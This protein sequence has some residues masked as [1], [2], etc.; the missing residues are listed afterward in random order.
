MVIYNQ[1]VATYIRVADIRTEKLN[2]TRQK[3]ESVTDAGGNW[4]Q[5]KEVRLGKHVA[6]K[7]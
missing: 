7:L 1:K 3:T 2:D 4:P 6:D 5:H